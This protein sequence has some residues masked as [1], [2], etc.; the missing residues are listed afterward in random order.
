MFPFDQIQFNSDFFPQFDQL[1]LLLYYIEGF[2]PTYSVEQG[3]LPLGIYP[4]EGDNKNQQNNQILRLKDIDILDFLW[5]FEDATE[6]QEIIRIYE[7]KR[8]ILFSYLDNMETWLWNNNPISDNLEN[9]ILFSQNNLTQYLKDYFR[10]FRKIK[11]IIN[12]NQLEQ[13]LLIVGM[14]YFNDL[15]QGL[16][17]NDPM[18]N[19][20]RE[21]ERQ[22]CRILM[23]F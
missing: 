16:S 8:F 18:Y 10:R 23:T 17:E 13:E 2:G 14:N 3:D 9:I 15:C 11:K 1:I 20:L 22:I 5:S 12:F 19:V 4:D 21:K 7:P 6:C